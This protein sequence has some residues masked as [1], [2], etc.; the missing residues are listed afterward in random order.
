MAG[1]TRI[2]NCDDVCQRDWIIAVVHA[3][4]SKVRLECVSGQIRASP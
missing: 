3:T 4:T 1:L 2:V